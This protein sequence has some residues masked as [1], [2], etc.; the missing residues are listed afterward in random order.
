MFEN[1]TTEMWI[2]IAIAAIAL[3]TDPSKI[4]GKIL[5]FFQSSQTKTDN[6][7]SGLLASLEEPRKHLLK[8]K[9]EAGLKALNT[10]TVRLCECSCHSPSE[11]NSNEQ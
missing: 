11:E 8:H 3:F 10:V 5:P 9:D 1:I 4:L 2:L 6:T 7:L